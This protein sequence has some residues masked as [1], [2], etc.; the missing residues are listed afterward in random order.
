[1]VMRLRGTSQRC[2]KTKEV[3]LKEKQTWDPGI[4]SP[5]EQT[6][7]PGRAPVCGKVLEFHP[8]S[9]DSR[10]AGSMIVDRQFYGQSLID[11]TEYS[12]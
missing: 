9:T 2:N 4:R 1:M 3:T 8:H 11:C 12:S 10:L 5:T 7:K 6:G